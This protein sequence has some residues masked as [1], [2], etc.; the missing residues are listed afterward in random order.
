MG[1]LIMALAVGLSF[2][3]GFR[4]YPWYLIFASGVL[5]TIGYFVAK[6]ATKRLL[7][8]DPIRYPT[9]LIALNSLVSGFV[10]VVGLLLARI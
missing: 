8:R 3:F 6:P 10:F 9:M 4:H 1:N 5:W 2:F 7:H